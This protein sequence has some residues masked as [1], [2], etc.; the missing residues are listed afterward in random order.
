MTISLNNLLA[1]APSIHDLDALTLP[2]PKGRGFFL[3]PARLLV[4][5]LER[6]VEA[7]CPEAFDDCSS[8]SLCPR[9]RSNAFARIFRAAL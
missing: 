6:R 7:V 2:L 9:V 8:V 1:R 3:Q 4:F 5:R